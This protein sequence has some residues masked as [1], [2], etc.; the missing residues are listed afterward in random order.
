VLDIIALE[1]AL[2]DLERIDP[3]QCRVV[4]LRYFAGMTVPETAAVLGVS[5]RTVKRERRMHK[6]RPKGD[7]PAFRIEME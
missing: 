7:F 6:L 2:E 3:V 1:E 4:E 5:E